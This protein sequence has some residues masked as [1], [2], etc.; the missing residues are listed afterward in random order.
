MA[1]VHQALDTVSGQRVALKQ[2]HRQAEEKPA[3]RS[4]ELFEREYHTLAEL[5]HP[6]IVAAM[7]Y[8]CDAD[9]PYYTME[10]LDG[11]DLLERSPLPWR[12]ACAI[13]RDVCSALSL[14][15]S[16]RM[17]YRD[18]SPRNVRC[19]SDGKAKLLDFGAM[20]P[21]GPAA[22]AVCTPSVASPEVVYRLPLDGRS[23]LYALGAML[24]F[25]LVGRSA[26]P[27]RS[28]HQLIEL[29]KY[30]VQPPSELDAEIPAALD[31][32]VMDLLQLDPQLRPAS[33]AEVTQRLC[34]IAGLSSDEQV[35]V[36]HAYLTTPTLVG[37][38]RE[39]AAFNGM[40]ARLKQHGAGAGVLL[41]GAPGVGRSRLLDAC[42][43]SAKL[44]GITVIRTAPAA[45]S[46]EPFAVARD[47]ASQ[48]LETAPEDTLEAASPHRH[49]LERYLPVLRERLSAP[50]QVSE[51]PPAERQ[52]RIQATLRGFFLDV[53]QR[54]PLLI[55]VDDIDRFDAESRALVTLLAHKA[56][57]H[58][59]MIVAASDAARS[60][61]SDA[62]RLL[63]EACVPVRLRPL[64]VEQTRALLA[65]I[66][67]DAPNLSGLVRR[68][69]QLSSGNPRNLMRL[70]Q[71]LVDRRIVRYA[72]GAWVLPERIEGGELPETM[73]Q[74]FQATVAA[75]EDD[76]RSLAHAFAACTDQRFAFDECL[77]LSAH[78]DPG[79]TL[80]SLD[81]LLTAEVLTLSGSA[82]ALS[83]QSWV[84][85]LSGALTPEL[86]LRLARIFERRGDGL[87][88]ARHLFQTDREIEGL[89]LLVAFARTSH[90]QT[91]A[92]SEAYVALLSTLPHD[93]VQIHETGIAL[94]KKLARPARDLHAIQIR[95]CGL[96]SQ[97]AVCSN[98]QQAELS[99]RAAK[100]AGLDIY[101]EL[102]PAL[103]AAERLQRALAAAAARYENT[104]EHDRVLDPKTAIG[105]LARTTITAIGNFSRTLDVDEWRRM[106]S[107]APLS[108]LSPAVAV[109]DLLARGFG[110]RVSGR[111]E[112]AC[113]IY[114]ETLELLDGE[115]G[116][117]LDPTF[118]ESVRAA[119]PSIL[120]TMEAALG[121]PSCERHAAAV[122]RSPLYQGSALSIRM[123]HRLWLGDVTAGD[124]LARE[125]ELWWLEQPRQ[126]ASD[127]QTVLWTLQAHAAS[128]DL[129]HTRHDLETIERIAAK[130]RSWQ[131]IA[132]W[133]RGEY[134]RIRGD[135]AAALAALDAALASMQPGGH[136]IW[137]L[138]A[139]ARVQV[140][141]EQRRFAEARDAGEAYLRAARAHELGY[142]I[143]YIRMPLAVATAKLG[144]AAAAWLQAKAA[145]DGFSALGAQGLNLG[146]AYDAATRVAAAL[147]DAAALQR[148]AI[149]CKEC[150][151]AY[152]NPALAAKY[153]RV[154]RAARRK[155]IAVIP[156]LRDET[157]ASTMDRSQMESMLQ[158]CSTGQDRLECLLRY[159]VDSSGAEEGF[160]YGLNDG[161][162]ELRAR[163]GELQP[164]V[165]IQLA[166]QR[167]L[168]QELSGVEEET[169][170]ADTGSSA[171]SEWTSSSGRCYRPLLLTHTGPE[172]F[173][174][175]G[176]VVLAFEYQRALRPVAEMVTHVSRV[177]TERG[178]LPAHTIAQ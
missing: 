44:A 92:S 167:H 89:D 166:A 77:V 8:G 154:S 90:Q 99:R 15:H 51:R 29:W 38:E 56:P 114:R 123:L 95:L 27:A 9:L 18:L 39:I 150:L 161:A 98:G 106:P 79:R 143:N 45:A 65:S 153:Q 132:A 115:Q 93:W 49:V 2:L 78:G 69:H 96:F 87:R 141:C 171:S 168:A 109:G 48:L 58:A 7:D 148:Y 17:V 71:H 47:I 140:L 4:L 42:V 54:R 138:A 67:G 101:A 36:A 175:N 102:D 34:A 21:M 61:H 84:A 116:A 5:A 6:R 147:G 28:F 52:A 13:A 176:L 88:A 25:T 131:P 134:E 100:A 174:V 120:G 53:A 81:Q 50:V 159:I 127:L 57:D 130:L 160:L 12:E 152:P 10:L 177:L 151:L 23:D 83:S 162:P 125:R 11:G 82:Y 155:Q 136:Q 135:H 31:A 145:I 20:A 157:F 128:D 105:L 86:H 59:L 117:G 173:C 121:L 178:D 165:D 70:A 33:A 139:G 142:V 22:S 75:L 103:S 43:L 156:G 64:D 85:P 129:T 118:V 62:A 110:A 144:D 112:V 108:P 91:S 41:R 68:L 80:K 137:P 26:Y 164:P 169:A 97:N 73:A 172:G 24:Y 30:P 32:L 146:L 37:R 19:T 35:V 122:E 74:A 72:A 133:A 113:Q 40:L 66:F 158:T 149:L 3:Q 104:P 14:V 1:T 170:A 46:N 16:R 119:L 60:E 63:S 124:R 111:F 107:L 163:T 94:C 76:A 55:A 126:Q